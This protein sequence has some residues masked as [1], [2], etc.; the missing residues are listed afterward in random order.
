MVYVEIWAKIPFRVSPIAE[1]P[2]AD[3]RGL[4]LSSNVRDTLA[5]F[6]LST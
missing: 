2:I 5:D 1:S 4:K 6:L 3:F